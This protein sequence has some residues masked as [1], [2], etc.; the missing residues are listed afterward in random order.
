MSNDNNGTLSWIWKTLGNETRRLYL[1][2]FLRI[3]GALLLIARS[4]LLR[5]L[6]D[7]A[8]EE[9]QRVFRYYIPLLASLIV[10]EIILH[11]SLNY[12]KGIVSAR[13]EMRFREKA[14]SSLLFRSYDRVSEIHSGDWTGRII[15]ESRFIAQ[16]LQSLLPELF[17]T[18]VQFVCALFAL[19]M[20]LPSSP[21]IVFSVSVLMGLCAALIKGRL[22]HLHRQ[23]QIKDSRASGL[24]QEQI[25]SLAVIRSF[26]GEDRSI[27]QMKDEFHAVQTSRHHWTRFLSI[28]FGG[29]HAVAQLGFLGGVAVCSYGVYHGSITPGSMT[30]LIILAQQLIAPLSGVFAL[31]PNYYT[32]IGSA[33]RLMEIESLPADRINELKSTE[34]I[35][36]IYDEKLAC[37]GMRDVFFGYHT[38]KMVLKRFDFCV[39]KGEFIALT[40]DSGS[41]KTSVLK[42]LMGFYFP[43]KGS[44]YVRDYTGAEQSLDVSFRRLFAYVPQKNILISGTIRESISFGNSEVMRDDIRIRSALE[45]ACAW[46]FVSKLED[47]V[48]TKLGE[49]GFGFSEGETQRLAIARAL[50][51]NRP[52]LIL[53]EATSALDEMTEKTVLE[54]LRKLKRL[55]VIAVTHRPA[56]REVATREIRLNC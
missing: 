39:G 4:L 28:C 29:I 56:A 10:A 49:Y 54:N 35:Q 26:V 52:V 38:D 23:I 5:G 15:T 50:L 27:R 45:I 21:A 17:G 6:M 14:F 33:G 44:L 48:D 51:A 43:G 3:L 8:I 9:D 1:L 2:S 19:H 46:D 18:V 37:F 16:G 24:M 25:A 55:T 53:D 36:H 40:G 47:G 34:E 11:V 7:S 13:I 32:V 31:I 20:I 41:G 42:L 30:A 22:V 12:L